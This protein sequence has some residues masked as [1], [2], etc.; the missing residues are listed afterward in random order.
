MEIDA[1]DDT[2]ATAKVQAAA[3]LPLISL[4]ELSKLE[5]PA[6]FRA[7]AEKSAAQAKDACEKARAA[8]ESASDLIEETYAVAAKGAVDY[9]L[10]VFA[11]ARANVYAAFD[12]TNE[13]VNVTS[14]AQA[15]EPCPH[16]IPG[17]DRTDQGTRE[18]GP[19]ARQRHGRADQNRHRQGVRQFPEIKRGAARSPRR[20]PRTCEVVM[21]VALFFACVLALAA[22][23]NRAEAR[24]PW[25]IEAAWPAP[26]GHFQP[27]AGDI[28]TG[29]PLSPSRAEQ[30]SLDR[31]IDEKLK[32]CRGC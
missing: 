32:I 30:E 9:N 6:A 26:A 29:I 13:I 31:D 12:F 23:V 28:P 27:R 24:T 17:G 20:S 5:L 11:A 14:L 16:A 21:R 10:K 4:F 25:M 7:V 8:A 3:A 22:T 18:R 15:V 19:E 1:M 2:S